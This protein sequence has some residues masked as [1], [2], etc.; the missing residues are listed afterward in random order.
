MSI[1]KDKENR[2]K[3]LIAVYEEAKKHSPTAP[4]SILFGLSKYNKINLKTREIINNDE[5]KGGYILGE[6]IGLNKEEVDAIVYYC[7]GKNVG[8]LG[9]F[10]GMQQFHLTDLGIQY[11][12][13]LENEKEVYK[14]NTFNISGTLNNSPIQLQQNS[15]NSNQIQNL[16]YSESDLKEFF[17]LL[18]S[19]LENLPSDIA[20]EINT[21]IEYAEKQIEKKRDIKTQLLNI[22]N[23]IKDVGINTFANLLASPIFEMV[24]PFLGM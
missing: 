21:E 15:N 16:S 11:L 19:E 12:E 17:E 10:L 20:D 23:L 24:K 3:Y 1:Q 18:K 22:G 14:M 2:N 5:E 9:S 7:A 13:N 4:T 6:Q 8:Y